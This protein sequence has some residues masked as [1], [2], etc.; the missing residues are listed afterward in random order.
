MFITDDPNLKAQIV[1]V[2]G[3]TLK[4]KAKLKIL[5]TVFSDNLKWNDNV[6]IGNESILA[7]VKKR[8]NALK[9]IKNKVSLSFA[10]ELGT[11]IFYSKFLYHNEIWGKT[12]RLNLNK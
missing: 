12:T 7:Q 2:I 9:Y 4:H 8:I 3:I 6:R 1:K 10:K 11:S 5:G